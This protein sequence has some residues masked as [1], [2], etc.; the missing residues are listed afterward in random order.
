MRFA[1]SREFSNRITRQGRIIGPTHPEFGCQMILANA[2]DD[3]SAAWITASSPLA[4]PFTLSEPATV[5]H[6][7]WRNGTAPGSNH[8]VGIYRTD[9]SRV[10]SAGSTVGSGTASFVQAVDV[11]DTPI[12]AGHYYLVRVVDATTANRVGAYQH[13]ASIHLMNLMGC[14]Q[15]AT[16]SIPLPDPLVGMGDV[17][18]HTRVNPAGFYVKAPL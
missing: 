3:A 9:W 4:V 16:A 18:T 5:T 13:N 6:L 10:I 7:W 11:T 1:P 17:T 15:S 14:K 2:N 12:P 8:D